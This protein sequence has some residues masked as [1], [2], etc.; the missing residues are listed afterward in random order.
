MTTTKQFYGECRQSSPYYSTRKLADSIVELCRIRS[1][2]SVVLLCVDAPVES[3]TLRQLVSSGCSGLS[4]AAGHASKF[5]VPSAVYLTKLPSISEHPGLLQRHL[6][7]TRQRLVRT[8]SL[9]SMK[10]LRS[11]SSI[12]DHTLTTPQISS[13]SSTH[14]DNAR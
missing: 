13:D 3:A 1:W 5:V 11:I 8:S 12:F 10:S 6:S 9:R 4:Y 2:Y 7:I 14:F